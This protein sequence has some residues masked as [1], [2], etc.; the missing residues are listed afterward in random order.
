MPFLLLLLVLMLALLDPALDRGTEL[1]RP[2]GDM[3]VG[4]MMI[5]MKTGNKLIVHSD[6]LHYCLG[7]ECHYSIDSLCYLSK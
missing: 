4:A 7:G 5:A 2:V 6:L 3:K 1:M